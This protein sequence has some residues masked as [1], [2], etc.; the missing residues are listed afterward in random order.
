CPYPIIAVT[1]TNGKTT[2]VKLLEHCLNSAGYTTK[3]LGNV[4]E[5]LTEIINYEKLDFAIV[6][7]SS[8]QLEAVYK[9]KPYIGVLLNIDEDHLDRHKTMQNYINLKIGLFKNCDSHCYAVI[10]NQQ[11]ILDNFDNNTVNKIIVNKDCYINNEEVVYQDEVLCKVDEIN[12]F[13]FM[14][15]VLSTISVLKIIG[16]DNKKILLGLNTFLGLEHRLEYVDTINNN[17][18]YNDS[19]AT[20]PHSTINAVRKLN[21]YNNITLLLGGQDKDFDFSKMIDNLPDNVKNIVCFGK[22]RKKI[23]HSIKNKT[24]AH[25]Q[26]DLKSAVI[27]ANSITHDGVILLS[28]ACA[29]FDEFS[30]FEQRGTYFKQIVASLKNNESV[31]GV[32]C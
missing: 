29:S 6:E 12:D 30:G 19:K 18:F 21:Q 13:T 16:L 24:M 11:E 5:P 10:N 27:Y 22:C 4:G 3:T 9:F 15:N 32:V 25:I 23:L 31:K 28:P 17:I 7:V 8:F 1:G 2:V 14:D 26:P 20:N